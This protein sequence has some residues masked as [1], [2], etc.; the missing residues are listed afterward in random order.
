MSLLEQDIT[1][2]GQVDEKTAEQLEFEAGGNNEEYEVEG[3]C[4]SAIYVRESETSHLPGFY[5]LV[6]WKGYS[7]NK[8]T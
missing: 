1:W 6:F 7:E 8:S 4:D 3:I 2:K 5:Y